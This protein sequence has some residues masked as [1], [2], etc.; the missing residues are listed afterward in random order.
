MCGVFTPC[1]NFPISTF[2]DPILLVLSKRRDLHLF[3]EVSIALSACIM[4]GCPGLLLDSTEPGV[5]KEFLLEMRRKS[6][7][8]ALFT[9]F[10]KTLKVFDVT[11]IAVSLMESGL[12][13]DRGAV[14]DVTLPEDGR[15]GL[16]DVL[17]AFH[18]CVLVYR[19]TLVIVHFKTISGG[20]LYVTSD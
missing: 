7:W 13:I 10:F 16:S 9:K 6:I 15:I 17:G 3:Q 11:V 19:K 5:A 1:Q 4:L 14:S 2:T 18:G 12:T 8:Q 20:A